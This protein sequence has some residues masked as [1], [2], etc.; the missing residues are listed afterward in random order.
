MES[1]KGFFVAHLKKKPWLT[2]DHEIRPMYCDLTWPKTPEGSW[3]N[4]EC[5][6]IQG[7]LGDFFAYKLARRN[8]TRLLGLMQ[9][10]DSFERFPRKIVHE[11]WV[12]V[13]VRYRVS[14]ATNRR[15]PHVFSCGECLSSDSQKGKEKPGDSHS[16]SI[17]LCNF[18]RGRNHPKKMVV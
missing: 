12:G 17:N 3:G 1:S 6:L 15:F 4:G 9:V 7:N 13:I 10:Y 18:F 14:Q 11:V 2:R 8:G 5:P 16:L